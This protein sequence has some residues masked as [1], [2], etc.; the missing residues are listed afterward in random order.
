MTHEVRN[1]IVRPA[2]PE[3]RESHLRVRGQIEQELSE[4]KRWAR[5]AAGATPPR[6]PSGRCSVQKRLSWSKPST[7]MRPATLWAIAAR[8]FERL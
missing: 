3:E 5:E 6:F 4:L 1:R 7:I 8:S 2:T